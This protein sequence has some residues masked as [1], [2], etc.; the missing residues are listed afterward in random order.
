M[1]SIY[2]K[3]NVTQELRVALVFED[4]DRFVVK[5]YATCSHE[6]RILVHHLHPNLT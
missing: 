5:L 2:Y 3:Y 1:D 6:R 4:F